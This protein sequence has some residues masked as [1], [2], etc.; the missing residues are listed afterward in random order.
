MKKK[1][2]KDKRGSVMAEEEMKKEEMAQA[3][4]EEEKKEE[5]ASAEEKAEAEVDALRSK[6]K[7]LE[8][9]IADL[10]DKAL[11][12][13]AETENYKKRL[14]QEKENAVRYAN[15]SLI[16]DLLDPLDN[17]SRAIEA[18]E[19]SKDF[20]TI[21]T[22]V[23]MVEDQLHS[24]LKNN[25]GLE[26]YSP[27]GEDFDPSDM[28]ACMMQEAEGIDREKVMQ[29]FMKGYKLHGKV[30]RAAKVAVGKPKSN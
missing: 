20:D 2:R 6:V 15:E 18:S 23:V 30:I 14:R 5:T 12:E 29:V 28:E 3:A 10:R 1:N 16:K 17:F 25:W 8:E 9:T 7:E 13:A 27:E 11:R 22:G 21:R 24:I 26:S 19:K 4:P